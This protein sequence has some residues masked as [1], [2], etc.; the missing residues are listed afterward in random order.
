MVRTSSDRTNYLSLA[1]E[2]RKTIK[3]LLQFSETGTES[4]ELKE[5]L[6]DTVE[7]LRALS[8]GSSLFAHL[9]PRS[10]YEYYEQIRTLQEIQSVMKDENLA[11]RLS[12]LSGS[13]DANERKQNL[14]IALTFFSALENRALQRYNRSTG[15]A[16]GH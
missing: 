4:A 8:S 13:L 14:E 9:H 7:S 11:D 6:N 15:S 12:A 3:E 2:A 5:A 10:S 1:L 16:F